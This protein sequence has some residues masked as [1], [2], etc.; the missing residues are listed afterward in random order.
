MSYEKCIEE[1]QAASG[2]KLSEKDLRAILDEILRRKNRI[3]GGLSAADRVQRVAEEYGR[4]LEEAEAII[5]RNAYENASKRVARRGVQGSAPAPDLGIEAGL[6]G[7]NTP[8]AGSRDSID[9][10]MRTMTVDWLGGMDIDLRKGGLDKYAASGMDDADVAKELSELNRATGKPGVTG[11]VRAKALAATLHKYQQAAMATVN[12]SGGWVKPFSGYVARTM[13]DPEKIRGLSTKDFLLGK[14]PPAEPARA[15]WSQFVLQHADL[16]RTFGGAEEAKKA[17]PQLWSELASG[18]HLPDI[19]PDEANPFSMVGPNQGRRA[20]ASRVIIWK[21]PEDWQLYNAKYGAGTT[22]AAVVASLRRSARISALMQRFGTHPQQA[23]DADLEHWKKEVA[24]DETKSR[25]LKRA[26]TKLRNQMK[27]L[28]GTTSRA[29]DL[30]SAHRLQSW[31]RWQRFAKL[32]SAPFSAVL[33]LATKA[34]EL[35]YQ[36]VP[37][38]ARW[39]SFLTDYLGK[40]TRTEDQQE[41]ADILRSGIDSHINDISQRFESGSSGPG[42]ASTAEN[43]FFKYTGLTPMT[44]NQRGAAQVI[45]ARWAGLRQGVAHGDLPHGLRT[46]MSGIGIGPREWNLLRAADWK[47]N[48]NDAYFEPTVVDRL[49]T[50]DLMAYAKDRGMLPE[51]AKADLRQRVLSFVHDR[52]IYAVLEPTARVR[53]TMTQG[54][55]AGTLPGNMIRIVGQFKAFSVAMLQQTWGR[56]IYGGGRGLDRLA[57]VAELMAS[58]L[59]LGYAAMTLRDVASGRTPRDPT[60]PSTVA[61]AFLAGGGLSIYGDFL[62]GSFSRYGASAGDMLLGPTL[63]QLSS[64]AD[65]KSTWTSGEDGAAQAFK[66]LKQNL[67]GQNIW[68]TREILDFLVTY[69]IQEFL[70]PGYLQRMQSQLEQQNHQSWWLQPTSALR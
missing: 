13:H 15:A 19:N 52:G 57:G 18:E 21:S 14:Y 30:V 38:L 47:V 46:I 58:S 56:E 63:G 29:A 26:E 51:D 28:D 50:A 23:F 22:S 34:G 16:D 49:E 66:I 60:E 25:S 11:N 24:G 32:G 44:D 20:S 48:G 1:I 45:M 67:P 5:K 69:R 9:L 40:Y 65:L 31:M 4:S 68:M 3:P 35:R 64:L 33:D 7:V 42:L 70:N 6:V 17:L 54:T 59:V 37:L 2:G 12:R 61:A 8:F 55:Q 43:L 41:V 62:F 27:V 10:A 39:Q 36:G 53:A